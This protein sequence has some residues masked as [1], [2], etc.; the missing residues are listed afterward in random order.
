MVS[1]CTIL[2][3]SDPSIGEDFIFLVGDADPFLGDAVFAASTV[4][5]NPDSIACRCASALALYIKS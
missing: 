5:L 4:A 2:A 3:F 1:S